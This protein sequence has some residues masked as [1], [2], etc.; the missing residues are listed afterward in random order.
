VIETASEEQKNYEASIDEVNKSI[1]STYTKE[2]SGKWTTYFI[3]PLKQDFDGPFEFYQSDSGACL[4]NDLKIRVNDD[5]GSKTIKSGSYE[6]VCSDVTE[7]LPPRM[8]MKQVR[9]LLKLVDLDEEAAT[10]AAASVAA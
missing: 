7:N 5:F 1:S 9:F 10:L 8:Q 6:L 4:I 2:P 3:N